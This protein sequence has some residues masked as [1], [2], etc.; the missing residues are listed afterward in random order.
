MANRIERAVILAAGEG[1]RLRP[2]TASKPKVM[3]PIAN[4]PILQYVIEALAQNGVGDILI[5]VGY[6]KEQVLDY[7]GAGER[8]GVKIKYVEQPQQVGTAHALK[9]VKGSIGGDFL[10]LSGDNIIEPDTIAR[11]ISAEPTA[12][13][14]KRQ[15]NVS[16]YGVVM[17]RE[18][19]VKEIVEKPEEA[20]SNLVNTG[21][22]AFSPD[23][24]PFLEQETDLTSALGQM[25]GSGYSIT[26]Y[27]SDYEWLDV[28]YPWDILKLNDSALKKVSPSVAG[29]L[30]SGVTI[31]GLVS[32]GEGTVIRAN[33]YIVGPVVIG[34]NCQIGPSA[35]ILPATSIGE[36]SVI[37]PFS[38]I[39]NSVI[40]GGVE[41]GPGC[42]IQDSVIDRG[43]LLRGHFTAWS[44]EAV[45]E[46]DGEYHKL[47]MGA[48]V[49]EHCHLEENV[50]VRPGIIVGNQCRVK[51]LRAIEENIPDG[52]LAV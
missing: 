8:F 35:H 27:E 15:E 47:R 50:I 3:I 10:V 16:K 7:F 28:V 37:S 4:K 44:G 29:S 17:V 23:I 21:I 49:G 22:Y 40:G 31:K 36:N 2:F 32:V 24:F 34:S 42:V 39:Q 25:T 51:G 13:L 12:I 9:Q 18:G 52:S 5:V 14:I 6:R 30:E 48:M 1:Q 19:R 33:S 41:V 38:Q 20:S 26:A 43:S 11:F 46:V 45:V